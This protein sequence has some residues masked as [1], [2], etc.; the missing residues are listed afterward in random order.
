VTNKTTDLVAHELS[1]PEGKGRLQRKDGVSPVR[2]AS[3]GRSSMF[4]GKDQSQKT[5]KLSIL[6]DDIE[7]FLIAQRPASEAWTI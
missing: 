3:E 2:G 5:R 4:S 7:A 6:L 1:L